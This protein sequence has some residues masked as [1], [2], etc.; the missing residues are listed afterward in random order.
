[1]STAPKHQ[2]INFP[3]EELSSSKFDANL[4]R[5]KF[6][7]YAHQ[8]NRDGMRALR[9]PN[10]A[11]IFKDIYF[12]RILEYLSVHKRKNAAMN[13]LIHC[14]ELK[15]SSELVVNNLIIFRTLEYHPTH[16]VFQKQKTSRG[17]QLRQNL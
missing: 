8:K 12:R 13:Y 16:W 15:E 17:K 11:L 9:C 3:F 4:W 2:Q 7:E 1:M 5:A 6:D 10:V 14:Q